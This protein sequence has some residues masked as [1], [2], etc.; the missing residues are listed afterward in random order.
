MAEPA[1]RRVPVPEP[2]TR[3]VNVPRVELPRTC[4]K[5][6]WDTRRHRIW[7]VRRSSTRSPGWALT[8]WPC[9][10]CRITTVE[11][12]LPDPEDPEWEAQAPAART[13]TAA[14]PASILRMCVLIASWSETAGGQCTF[15][16][17]RRGA[18]CPKTPGL[19]HNLWPG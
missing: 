9:W 11:E 8:V 14:E 12:P 3:N 7:F 13:A 17:D 18:C 2:A 19:R 6:G 15:R 1:A 10:P 5:A 4:R 16:P